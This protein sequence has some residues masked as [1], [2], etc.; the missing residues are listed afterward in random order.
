[1]DSATDEQDLNAKLAALKAEH[2]QLFKCA[3]APGFDA[4]GDAGDLPYVSAQLAKLVIPPAAAL[5][6]NV[7]VGTNVMVNDVS[8]A[9]SSVT[10]SL[11]SVAD[12][13]EA[14]LPDADSLQSNFRNCENTVTSG[15]L[16]MKREI[17]KQRALDAAVVSYPGISTSKTELSTTEVINLSLLT[18][19][20]L[21]TS[22]RIL[23]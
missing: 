22:A 17:M 5:L 13:L 23:I 9:V 12:D 15:Y 10:S 20:T 8:N 4:E 11:E 19:F 18:E 14:N 3:V 21:D 2:D 1:M 6:R 7:D 16:M